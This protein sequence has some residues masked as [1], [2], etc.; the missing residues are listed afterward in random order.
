MKGAIHTFSAPMCVF[1][2]LRAART[3]RP[4]GGGICAKYALADSGLRATERSP[5][6]GLL[7]SPSSPQ[8]RS[9]A[10][11]RAAD[12]GRSI[13]DP[14]QPLAKRVRM[15]VE[16]LR[17][18]A[19]GAMSEKELFERGHEL[20]TALRVVLCELGHGI[21]RCVAHTT[22]GGDSEEVLVRAGCSR[23]PGRKAFLKHDRP[24]SACWASAKPSANA[25]SLLAHARD[26]NRDRLLEIAVDSAE[27]ARERLA[28]E[29]RELDHGV[30]TPRGDRRALE[31]RAK[32]HVRAPR[33]RAP[34]RRRCAGARG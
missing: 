31:R 25:A 19:D 30:G 27:L 17:G 9:G 13:A 8:S 34:R 11:R 22:V 33:S 29:S 1:R 16:R 21:D 18:R 3:F 12:R 4:H 20:G 24:S 6:E 7:K 5:P 10:S 2:M 28:R 23:R 26:T 15:D 32:A 14:A